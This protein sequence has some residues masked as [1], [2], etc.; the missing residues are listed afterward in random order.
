MFKDLNNAHPGR[1]C[2]AYIIVELKL[3]NNANGFELH[4]NQSYLAGTPS[5]PRPYANGHMGSE[6]VDYANKIQSL[7]VN[8]NR[9]NLPR[10]FDTPGSYPVCFHFVVP[11]GYKWSETD[12]IT[13]VMGGG[14]HADFEY[15][16]FAGPSDDG[17]TLY[18]KYK[19]RPELR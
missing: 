15:F 11:A 9:I 6:G 19:T 7:V 14:A 3:K 13:S 10:M 17:R 5:S 2:Y 8:N 18:V 16:S 12:P 4:G 1:E